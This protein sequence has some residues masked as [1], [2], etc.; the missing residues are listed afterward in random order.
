MTILSTLDFNTKT[1]RMN[2]SNQMA[3][4][5]KSEI[6]TER[7]DSIIKLHPIDII[8]MKLDVFKCFFFD[9]MIVVVRYH[10]ELKGIPFE[11]LI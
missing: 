4:Q 5:I 10:F 9:E 8:Q 11:I 6:L 2:Q 7:S 1:R 3:S